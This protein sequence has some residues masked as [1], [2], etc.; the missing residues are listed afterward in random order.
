[1]Y[2]GELGVGESACRDRTIRI[3][4]IIERERAAA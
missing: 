1:L 4:R 3:I 2:A